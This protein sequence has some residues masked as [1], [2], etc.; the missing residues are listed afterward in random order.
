MVLDQRLNTEAIAFYDE[1]QN[2]SEDNGYSLT[3]PFTRA[4]L[5]ARFSGDQ[6]GM[7][8]ARQENER[9]FYD[10]AFSK[11]GLP[12]NRPQRKQWFTNPFKGLDRFKQPD[13]LYFNHEGNTVS[14]HPIIGASYFS[15]ENGG[16]WQRRAGGELQANLG[17]VGLYGS[18]RDVYELKYLSQDSALSPQEGALYKVNGDGS[19]EFSETRGGITYS[20]KGGYVGLVRDFVQWGYGYYGTNIFDVN[21]APFAQVKLHLNPTPWFRFDYFHGSLQSGV[22][23]STSVSNVNGVTTYDFFNKFIAANMLSVRPWSKLWLSIGNS[24]IYSNRT[25]ELTY[26]IPVMFYKSVDHYLGSRGGM[27]AGGEGNAQM[28]AA[29]SLRPGNGMHFYSTLYVDEVSF[30]RMLDPQ[31][32]SNWFS[33]KS[34]FRWTNILPNTTFTFEHLRSNPMVYK[35]FLETTTFENAGYNMGHYLRDNAREFVLALRFKSAYW[36]ALEG[37]YRYAEKGQDLVDDRVTR[38]PITG[39]LLVQGVDFLGQKEWIQSSYRFQLTATPIY[40][41]QVFAGVERIN[42]PMENDAYQVPYYRGS[43]TTWSFGTHWGF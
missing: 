31:R 21:T 35:H 3:R 28:F 19:R 34:G 25:P 13:M 5:S 43:T 42:R 23:D 17:R 24:I 4:D 9:L 36:L 32:H 27:R 33:L 18:V 26:F 30:R 1:L 38:D 37:V 7:L 22:I 41:W 2:L 12:E 11:D 14:I 16:N 29:A 10:Q 15:N 6:S 8:T 20:F 40:R 39:I